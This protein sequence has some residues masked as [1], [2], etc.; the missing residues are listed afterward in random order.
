MVM[1]RKELEDL[2]RKNLESDIKLLRSK[3]HDY[4]PD[5]D[6]DITHNFNAI[7]TAVKAIGIDCT[8]PHG[9]A[10]FFV[11]HKMVRKWALLNNNKT[12]ENESLDDTLQDQRN[13]TNLSEACLRDYFRRKTNEQ[14]K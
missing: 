7:A 8:K 4:N 13:Y 3:G 10:D 14:S 11:I 12:P 1:T 9:A 5:Q 6:R 2:L